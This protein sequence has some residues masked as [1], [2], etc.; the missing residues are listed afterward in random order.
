MTVVY[1]TILHIQRKINHG[2]GGQIDQLILVK[3]KPRA[4]KPFGITV[5]S[6]HLTTAE[7]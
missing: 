1:T 7:N 2:F 5:V 4:C 3:N 6:Q